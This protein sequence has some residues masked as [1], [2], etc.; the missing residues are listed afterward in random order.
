MSTRPDAIPIESVSIGTGSMRFFR[1]G[2][3]EKTLVILPGLSV[4]SVMGAAE[5]IAAAYRALLRS[6][7]K[8]TRG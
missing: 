5:A 3:G 7:V 4:Q 8:R 6:R 2:R 1:F